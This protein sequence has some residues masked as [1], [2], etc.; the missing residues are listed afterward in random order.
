[1][2]SSMMNPYMGYQYGPYMNQDRS[3]AE[4]AAY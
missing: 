3:K 1:M 2:H 4:M